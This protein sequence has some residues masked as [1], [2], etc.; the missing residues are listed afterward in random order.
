MNNVQVFEGNRLETK[1]PAS[2]GKEERCRLLGRNSSGEACAIP[3]SDNLL[4]SHLLFLGGIGTGKTNAIFQLVT[5]LRASMTDR[6]VMLIF[7]TKGDFHKEFY[8]PGDPVI[9]NDSKATGTSRVDYW[10][11]F[12]EIGRFF[13]V[14][15]GAVG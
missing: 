9:S 12:R 8:R 15:G 4:S 3:L 2:S 10:N 5:Q 11:L 6:D 1:P 13:A 14:F 7:D